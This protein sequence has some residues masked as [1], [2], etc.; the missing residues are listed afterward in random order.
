VLQ[1]VAK[2]R[3]AAML[4]RHAPL[5]HGVELGRIREPHHSDL[6]G[7]RADR[8]D[9]GCRRTVPAARRSGSK[10]PAT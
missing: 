7:A 6:S 2:A 10:T 1:P 5:W 3:I 9:V 4:D 8:H